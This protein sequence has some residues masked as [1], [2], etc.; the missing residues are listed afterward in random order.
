MLHP[1]YTDFP[2]VT[3]EPVVCALMDAMALIRQ[4]A[5]FEAH[6]LL[7]SIAVELRVDTA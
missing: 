6:E 5:Y 2:F 4:G 3:K 1:R 7:E